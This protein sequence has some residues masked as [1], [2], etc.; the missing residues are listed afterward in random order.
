[1]QNGYAAPW[2]NIPEHLIKAALPESMRDLLRFVPLSAVLAITDA[3]GGT[4]LY[5]PLHPQPDSGLGHLI[6][7]GDARALASN[8]GG[9]DLE[10]PRLDKVRQRARHAAVLDGL[11]RGAS[12]RDVAR[13]FNMTTRNVRRI[14]AVYGNGFNS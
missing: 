3:Y 13:A 14:Q 11:A 8:V 5:I 4:R 10:I 9:C 6:G 2:N 1:M 7:M 12:Q